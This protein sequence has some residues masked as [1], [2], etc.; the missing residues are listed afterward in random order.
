[1]G[2]SKVHCLVNV[3]GIVDGRPV[4]NRFRVDALK[5][6]DHVQ[7]LARSTEPGLVREIGGVDY[8]CVALPMPDRI[9]E[10]LADAGRVVDARSCE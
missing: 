8:Q 7:V 5:A 10:Q 6:L 3:E 1:M 4:E 2:Y 9:A